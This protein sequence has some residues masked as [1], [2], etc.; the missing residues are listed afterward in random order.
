MTKKSWAKGR[1]EKCGNIQVSQETL[2]MARRMAEEAKMTIKEFIFSLLD[3]YG[4]RFLWMLEKEKSEE[5]SKI[6]YEL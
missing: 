3:K 4:D 2:E 1:R 6:P 5:S